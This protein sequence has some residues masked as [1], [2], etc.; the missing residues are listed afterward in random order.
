[1]IIHLIRMITK[2][3]LPYFCVQVLQEYQH[4]GRARECGFQKQEVIIEEDKL[5]RNARRGDLI[6]VI[7][8]FEPMTTRHGLRVRAFQ[9]TLM[10]KTALATPD[11]SAHLSCALV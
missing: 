7:V 1:M 9:M 10:H 5:I 8:S 11:P 3:E 4:T 6:R 2:L